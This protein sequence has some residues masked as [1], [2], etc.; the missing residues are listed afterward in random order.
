MSKIEDDGTSASQDVE[1]D[2]HLW[3]LQSRRET[4]G[5]ES[6]RMLVQVHIAPR[7]RERIGSTPIS[8][9]NCLFWS[10]VLARM[11]VCLFV[12]RN[13]FEQAIVGVTDRP[14]APQSLNTSRIR[15]RESSP[16]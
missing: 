5:N 16:D 13:K 1:K 2:I 15:P 14:M 9:Q 10:C 7:E 11:V 12:P 8:W 6:G 4:G 3:G